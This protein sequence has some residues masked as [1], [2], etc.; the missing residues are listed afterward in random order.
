MILTDLQMVFV[1]PD[2]AI[3]GQTPL[4]LG[5]AGF[6]K[7]VN[8]G[9]RCGLAYRCPISIPRP[10]MITRRKTTYSTLDKILKK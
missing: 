1:D 3:P 2:H 8:M 6:A 5:I 4:Q 10:V 7:D 9:K